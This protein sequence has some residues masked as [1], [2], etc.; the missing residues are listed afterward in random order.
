MTNTQ[1]ALITGAARRIGA[2]IAHKLHET[3]LNVVLHY[4]NSQT[5]AEALCNFL[6]E[7][8]PH[9][10]ITLSADLKQRE[11]FPHFLELAA[12]SWG[13]LDVLVNNASC[14]I[15]TPM[16]SVT[17]A[18]WDEIMDTNLKAPF[19]LSQFAAP[20]L[21]S[22]KGCIINIAD[23]HTERAFRDYAVYCVSKA[24]L[25]SATRVLAKEL[26]PNVRV[27]AISP[28]MMIWPENENELPEALKLKIINETAL[29]RIGRLTDVA[30]A[31][32]F[33]VQDADYITGQVLTIDGGRLL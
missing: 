10:A 23:V 7:K 18:L 2:E 9:S 11:N 21:I 19:F 26:G 24:G 15:K 30:K 28:G 3:G 5:D 13:R 25:V 22:T 6:N 29:K 16:G 27:N 32:L 4:L 14:F 33:F 17:E 31:V 20:H 1:V 8:R 12:N